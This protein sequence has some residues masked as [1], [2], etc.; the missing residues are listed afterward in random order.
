MLWLLAFGVHEQLYSI[1]SRD[2]QHKKSARP[3]PIQ[4]DGPGKFKQRAREMAPAR[5]ALLLLLLGIVLRST[6]GN[7]HLSYDFYGKSCPGIERLVRETIAPLFV[8]DPTA[9]AALLRL[10]FHDCQVQVPHF[11][12]TC[13]PSLRSCSQVDFNCAVH[14]G[15]LFVHSMYKLY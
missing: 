4:A 9:P 10:M 8:A 11:W 3:R 13:I 14:I 6:L 1:N 5:D 12:K 7:D 15:T 2:L